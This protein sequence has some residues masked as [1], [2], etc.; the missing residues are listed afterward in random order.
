MEKIIM[1]LDR[2]R[3]KFQNQIFQELTKEKFNVKVCLT[4]I[5]YLSVILSVAN[6]I[7]Y[8]WICRVRNI[9]S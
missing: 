2:T 4:E 5:A 8:T 7:I 1:L 6:Y 9:S 3:Q